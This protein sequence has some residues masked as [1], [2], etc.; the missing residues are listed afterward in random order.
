MVS[1]GGVGFLEGLGE[2]LGFGR[3]GAG[4][5]VGVEG[6]ADEKGFDLVLADEA[7][8]GFEVGAEGGA[9][10]GEEGLGGEAERVGDGE[11]DAAVADVQREGAGV[12]HGVSVR[13]KN[14]G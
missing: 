5:A 7:G 8:D 11:T 3:L 13:G 6:V 1:E 10:E 14:R 2:G 4:R 9:V 12:R